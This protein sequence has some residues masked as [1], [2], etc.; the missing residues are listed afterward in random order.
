MNSDELL[1][2]FHEAD[3]GFRWCIRQANGDWLTFVCLGAMFLKH[4]GRDVA[5]WN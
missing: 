1:R 3:D 2:I 4:P 5:E